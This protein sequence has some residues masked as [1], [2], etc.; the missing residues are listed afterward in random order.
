MFFVICFIN[1]IEFFFKI[2]RWECGWRRVIVFCFFI[3]YCGGYG[4]GLLI[5]FLSEFVVGIIV[6]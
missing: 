6:D 4:G 5:F 1:G 2:C 3:F